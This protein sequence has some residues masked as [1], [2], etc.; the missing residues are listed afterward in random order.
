MG[1]DLPRELWPTYVTEIAGTSTLRRPR[2][3]SPDAVIACS[4]RATPAEL[5]CVLSAIVGEEGAAA[6][7]TDLERL[8]EMF[9]DG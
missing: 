5:A 9:P 8:K 1:H 3:R 2:V 7:A 6:G 4:W